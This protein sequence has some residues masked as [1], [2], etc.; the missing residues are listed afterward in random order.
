MYS[1][2]NGREGWRDVH[3]LSGLLGAILL[4]LTGGYMCTCNLL[5]TVCRPVMTSPPH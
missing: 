3:D 4:T 5:H 2:M 1:V